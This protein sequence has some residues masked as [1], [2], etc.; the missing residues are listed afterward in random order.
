[1][2]TGSSIKTDWYQTEVAVVITILV[3]NLKDEDVKITFGES[4]L[5][6]ELQVNGM[7][8]CLTYQL[9]H[10]VDP[11]AGSYKIMST[12]V[13][14]KLKKIDGIRWAKLEGDP[15]V[16][17]PKTIA[18]NNDFDKPPAYPTSKGTNWTAIEKELDEQEAKEKPEG[19]EALNKLF[20]EIYGKGSD[21]VKKAMNKSFMESGG[22]V[23]ST[24]WSE[25]GSKKVE[26]K[27]PDGTEFK[28]W[29]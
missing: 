13:E 9:A 12:K 17:T 19:E 24:N 5:E 27:P 6:V 2:A 20:Q 11:S 3:K 23:L 18:I 1:M 26:V 14:I 8:E 29:D 15:T 21:E 4:V 28:K 16:D 7:K 10:H 22:T 25:I